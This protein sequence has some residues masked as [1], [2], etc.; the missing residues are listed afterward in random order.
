VLRDPYTPTAAEVIS[1]ESVG[2]L[3]S[4]QQIENTE[5]FMRKL[6]A[7]M[8]VEHWSELRERLFSERL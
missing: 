4:D 2:I 6:D 7:T 5:D 8:L 3:G 1:S